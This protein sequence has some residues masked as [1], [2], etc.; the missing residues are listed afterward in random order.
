MK[1]QGT[2]VHFYNILHLSI[3]K[4]VFFEKEMESLLKSFSFLF[5]IFIKNNMP[6]KND[7]LFYY[8]IE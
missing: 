4:I 2:N 3:K 6:L 8:H 1:N 5:F 7:Y